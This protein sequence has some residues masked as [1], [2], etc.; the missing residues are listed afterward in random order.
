MIWRVLAVLVIA[1]H[2]AYLLFIPL[3]GFLAW[4]W[5]RI[6]PFHLAALAI[7]II[8]VTV[9]FD[10]PLTNLEQ[11]FERRAGEHPHGAFVNRYID[12]HL[13][14][15]GYDYVLQIAIVAAVV[16]SYAVMLRRRARRAP[17]PSPS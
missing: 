8:S 1:L 6:I 7:G 13:I 9:H 3:G 4:R 14:P 2:F 11:D 15:H 12:G 16:V 5:P 17:A 10:C